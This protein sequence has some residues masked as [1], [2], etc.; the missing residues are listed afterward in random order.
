MITPNLITYCRFIFAFIGI[1]LLWNSIGFPSRLIALLVLFIAG[2]T[3]LYDG[4]LA[5]R[6]GKVTVVGKILDPIADKFFILGVM[7]TYSHLGL[8]SI[9]WVIIIAVREI[10]LTVIR[11]VCLRKGVVLA[12]ESLGK[13]KTTS[14]MVSL[15]VSFAYLL[16]RDN[17]ATWT[18]WP[19]GIT[20]IFLIAQYVFLMIAVLLTIL[21]GVSFL[22]NL[23]NNS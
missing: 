19:T 4:W 21:S 2:I 10:L 7:L 1:V 11:L 16:T 6:W 15:A 22:R 9:I 5:R 17:F 14:Q 13:I 20:E 18:N 8:Y 23:K 3:D 12:A